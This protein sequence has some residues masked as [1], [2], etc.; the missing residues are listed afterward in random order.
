[1]YRT[2]H[3]AFHDPSARSH[4]WVERVVW[5]LIAISFVLIGIEVRLPSDEA[6]PTWLRA[7]DLIVLWAFVLELILRVGT[8]SPPELRVLTGTRAFQVRWH[9]LGRL[10]Y[11]FH[12]LIQLDLL[13]VLAVV[14]A[15]R[16]LRALR[17][18]RLFRGIRFFRYSSPLRGV[19]R[20]I[21]ENALV[22][23]FNIAFLLGVVMVGGISLFLVERGTNPGVNSLSD[24]IWWALVTITT[25]GFGDITPTTA[26]GRFIGGAVMV[27]GMF[28][29]A[30]F[31]GTVGGT[32][33]RTLMNLREDSFRMVSFTDHIVVCGY[34]EAADLLL[35]ALVEE[36]GTVVPSEIVV[37]AE[38][39]R[40]TSLRPE[41][42]W[43]SGDPTKESE[44]DKVRLPFARA[45]IVTGS[46][47][48]PIQHADAET[49]LTLFTLRSYLAKQEET[50]RRVRP[51]HVIAEILDPE[52]RDH[53]RTAGADEVVETTRF[54]FSLMAHAAVVPGSGNIMSRVAA[55]GA[56]SIYI[57][58]NP[59]T[60]PAPY[61]EV[62]DAVRQQC[63][64]VV[65][66]VRHVGAGVELNPTDVTIVDPGDAVVY[67]ARTAILPE[68]K[69]R[70]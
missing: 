14:P 22:Y 33:L 50:S 46:R 68:P 59:L 43:V 41:F 70:G 57:G 16:G 10:R 47:A 61:R 23:A 11:L 25:V 5:S 63:G 37:F 21:Q 28:T 30:L 52:N 53:A 67:L 19:T 2:L 24:G 56:H 42:M 66:G 58:Q 44:L 69:S 13:A 3:R 54:G 15:L 20:A 55:A 64:V 29:V 32:L 12:P 49:L 36:L 60:E 1:M 40:P 38:G 6:L 31:A 51:L 7:A 4:V 18:L 62:A 26:I 9:I 27:S 34:D 17:L 39:E 8:Y 45:A 65:I 35:N 48:V